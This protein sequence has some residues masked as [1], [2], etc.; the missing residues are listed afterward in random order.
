MKHFLGW[1]ID[2]SS[3]KSGDPTFSNYQKYPLSV[4]MAVDINK[5]K[6]HDKSVHL[7]NKN[8]ENILKL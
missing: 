6:I 7:L 8:A 5:L 1:S 3:K 4:S 2:Q